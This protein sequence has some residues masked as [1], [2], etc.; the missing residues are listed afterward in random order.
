[1]TVFSAKKIF[2]VIVI[3]ILFSLCSCAANPPRDGKAVEF[4]TGSPE[5]ISRSYFEMLKQKQWTTIAELYDPKALSDFREMMSFLSEVPDEAAS[6]VFSSLFGPGS[7]KESVKAMPDLQFFSS[8][9]QGVM[10]QAAQL[11]Q[12]DFKKIDVLGSVSE[13]DSLRHVITRTQVLLGDIDMEAMEVVSFRKNDDKWRI[14]MQGKMKGMAQH[15]RNALKKSV[16]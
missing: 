5:A 12:L 11:G 2:M 14:L 9:L 1:M 3:G 10:A 6:R 13:G 7:T 15:I 4:P 8:F 16:K